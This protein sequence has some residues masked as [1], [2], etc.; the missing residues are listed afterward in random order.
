MKLN[1]GAGD[2]KLEG[3][4]PIDR[5]LGTEVYPLTDYADDSVEEIRA[6]HILEHFSF[7]EVTKVIAEWVRVLQPGGKIRIAVPDMDKIAE[8]KDEPTRRFF[9]MGG[10][11]DSSDFHRSC[12]DRKL[13]QQHME[14]CGGLVNIQPWTSDNTDSASHPCSL[15]LEGI[16]PRKET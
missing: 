6:S 13:L 2:T 9:L 14:L 16:K 3:F 10:Q 1:L 15:N 5:K 12:F 4:I 8:M 7:D 11:L